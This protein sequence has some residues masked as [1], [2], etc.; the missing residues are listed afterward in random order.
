M[1][2]ED[3]ERGDAAVDAFLQFLAEDIECNP[4]R[5]RPM[6]PALVEQI[7]MLTKSIAVDLD[8]PIIGEVA[9]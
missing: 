5:L 6:P 2:C 3:D 4:D 9:L 8:E 7:E 1:R